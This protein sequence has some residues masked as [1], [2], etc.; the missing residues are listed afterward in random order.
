MSTKKDKKKI[1]QQRKYAK[2]KKSI[3]KEQS[4]WQ[5]KN[6]LLPLGIVLLL[7]FVAFIP[8]L[9]N[10]FVNWDD[11]VNLLDNPNLVSLDWESI[12]GIFTS[13]VIGG[14]NPLT[15]LT[16][17]F[18]RALVGFEPFL[19]HFDNLILHLLCTFFVYRIFL[20]MNLSPIAAGIGALLFGIHP[21][22]VESVAWV[23]E[24]KDVLFGF[25]YL[26]AIWLYIKYI[27]EEEKRT[28]RYSVIVLL[29]IAA[30]LSK[31]QAVAMPLSM[32]ALDYYFNR[33]LLDRKVIL[34]K[35]PF[36]VLSLIIGILGIKMLGEN[37]TLDDITG[38][39]FFERLLVGALSYCVYLAKLV[40]PY[41]MSAL[42]PYPKA[43]DMQFYIAPLG[44]LAVVGAFVYAYM[45]D[46]RA[47]AF[48]IAFFTVNVM[49][50]LQILSAGQ[51]F[52]A[53]RFTYMAYMGLF[54]IIAWGYD[55]IVAL[56]PNVKTMLL[57]VAAAYF[58]MCM[59]MTWQQNKTWENGATLWSNVIK[60][61]DGTTALPYSNRGLYYRE[62]KK[63]DLALK[64]F[65][66]ALR[67]DP[68]KATI[69][70]S[71]GKL[72]F[73]TDRLPLALVDYNNAIKSDPEL[74][75]AYANRGATFARQ[76]NFDKA[77]V[78]FNKC[79]EL[80]P[81]FKNGYLNR[82]LLFTKS[83]QYEEAIKDYD[84]YLKIDRYHAD[85][86]YE[87]G[88]ALRVVGRLDESLR[89]FNQAISLKNNSGFYYYER[90]KTYAQK[91]N[92]VAA[93]QDAQKAQQLG[94]EVDAGF[95]RGVE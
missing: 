56:K 13:S 75:E 84:A 26:W 20:L 74:A 40:F 4:F 41:K 95:L 79:V 66:S 50:V 11:D 12:K 81:D 92:K 53:D 33:P 90:A 36:F 6:F 80:D 89:D 71:R 8:T 5:N 31:I 70:N 68:D 14:Y 87:R 15:I 35:I 91:G 29:T 93:K 39:S 76:G 69:L 34:E 2:A 88:M 51:G 72:Y 52:L 1:K 67:I 16:F 49:F 10:A 32:I 22:R 58:A 78:D 42:Y 85:M 63:M 24:R 46:K 27:K 37:N 45:K 59:V 9:D 65:S 86:Y 23:T 62:K 44:V 30:L 57:G 25:F 64:D 21:M 43:I 82:S 3:A 28:F 94:T 73:D 61:Y 60:Y 83:G 48:G 55:K 54:F 7:T 19:Y 18:E 77:M 38:F 47:I 17:A